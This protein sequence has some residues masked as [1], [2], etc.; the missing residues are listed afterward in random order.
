[1]LENPTNNNCL[2]WYSRLGTTSS[3]EGAGDDLS[4]ALTAVMN[5]IEFKNKNNDA[6]LLA[7][8]LSQELGML[9]TGQLA[10]EYFDLAV[11]SYNR[12]IQKNDVD[13]T[14][15]FVRRALAH[16][17][18]T[19]FTQLS[20]QKR[21]NLVTQEHF[22]QEYQKRH[23]EYVELC[24]RLTGKNSNIPNGELYEFYGEMV[25][26]HRLWSAELF[27]SAEIRRAFDAREDRPRDGFRRGG[28]HVNQDGALPCYS[29]DLK[30][31]AVD[32]SED[33]RFVQL[34]AD[35]HDNSRYGKPTIQVIRYISATPLREH[36]HR[37]A[38]IM[39]KTYNFDTSVNED[40]EL[41]RVFEDFGVVSA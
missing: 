5:S 6:A 23:I 28:R 36:V 13:M 14:N 41:E 21:D 3:L 37:V 15:P 29:F 31:T 17:F 20:Y 8:A 1:M 33:P 10:K 34:K 25:L 12:V 40:N 27:G 7:G 30:L 22:D 11:A 4:T 35:E 38:G 32:G 16:K 9:S 24:Q 19:V 18:D 2:D 26:R 39:L